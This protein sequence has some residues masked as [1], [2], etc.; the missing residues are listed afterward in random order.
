[1]NNNNIPLH[2]VDNLN[3]IEKAYEAL[4]YL[5]NTN[6][7]ADSPLIGRILIQ[8]NKNLSQ[9]LELIRITRKMRA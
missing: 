9:E 8:L 3:E 7:D 6:H 5:A 1:M 4:A 2:N